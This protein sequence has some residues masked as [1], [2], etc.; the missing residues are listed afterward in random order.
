MKPDLFERLAAWRHHLHAHPEL[1]CHERATAA[2][3]CEKLSELGIPFAAGIGGHGVVATLRRGRSNR[4][5]GLRADMDALPV[6]ETPGRAHGSRNQGVM[7]ACGHDGHTASLLGAAAL[8]LEDPSWSGTV[9]CIFQPAE[10][11]FGGAQAMLEDGLLERFPVERIFGYHNWP[12]LEAGVVMV[13]AGPVMAA[14]ASFNI[15]LHGVA[16]HAA[17]PHDC[18]DPVQGLAH[19]IIA[20]N[21]I[22]ARNVDPQEAAVI[23]TCML[24]AGEASN[25]IAHEASLGGTI[26]ALTPKMMHFLLARVREVAE[27]TARAHQLSALVEITSEV[28]ATINHAAEAALAAR[29]AADAGLSLRG[30]IK[31][32]MAGEDFGRFLEVMPGA[33]AWIGNGASAGLHN[34][35]YDFNDEILPVAARYYAA[36]AR[37]ALA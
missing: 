28:P 7:H 26:R 33:Y 16:G 24:K 15:T 32:S 13:H 18:A 9:Q 36:V 34:E 6:M 1:S 5:V 27:H 11:G 2:F 17:M 3:V 37:A 31:P 29:A 30:D 20:L 23:S 35:A 8:L 21:A 25:L 4:A 22:V 10:E 12:G 19:L 14:A